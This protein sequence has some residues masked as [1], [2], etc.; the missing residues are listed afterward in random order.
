MNELSPLEA[1][2]LL[3]NWKK[4]YLSDQDDQSQE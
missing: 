4:K 3:F 2:N 1:L